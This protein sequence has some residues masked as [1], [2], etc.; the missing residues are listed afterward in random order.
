[1]PGV[2]V[3]SPH[4]RKR[5]ADHLPFCSTKLSHGLRQAA[6]HRGNPERCVGASPV[7]APAVIPLAE[8]PNPNGAN[9]L[10]EGKQLPREALSVPA[11]PALHQGGMAAGCR[12]PVPVEL[13]GGST[14]GDLCT[15]RLL[16]QRLG[17][18]D[19][20]VGSRGSWGSA[21]PPT[22][23]R[24]RGGTGQAALPWARCR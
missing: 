4:S 8:G 24:R 14:A 1:M 19:L 16:A 9:G 17:R 18:G 22:H 2:R 6:G 7:S 5:S 11:S 23:P 12:G 15:Q 20:T 3:S 21:A 10:S 13:R